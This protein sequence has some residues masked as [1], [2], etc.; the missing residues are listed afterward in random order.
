MRLSLSI[1]M[2]VLKAKAG[3]IL[4]TFK[5]YPRRDVLFFEDILAQYI[6]EC[7]KAGYG[8]E[9]FDIGKK[10]GASGIPFIPKSVLMLSPEYITNIVI[11][12]VWTNLGLLDDFNMVHSANVYTFSTRNEFITRIIGKNRFMCGLFA[13][14]AAGFHQRDA[15]CCKCTQTTGACSYIVTC[16]RK[17]FSLAAKD[18]EVYGRLNKLPQKDGF[19]LKKAL[20]G[21]SFQLEGNRMTFRGKTMLCVENTGFHLLGS[22]GILLDRLSDI[23]QSFFEKLVRKDATCN[24]RL[25]LLKT[26]LQSCGWGGVALMIEKGE[27]RFFI[28]HPPYGIQAEKDNWDFLA[29]FILGYLRTIDRKIALDRVALEGDTLVLSYFGLQNKKA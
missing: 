19:S 21:G 16:S 6:Q 18:F 23:T 7:E 2:D 26:I 28:E 17:P 11:K 10:W 9:I 12:N 5:I 15:Q 29:Y 25:V 1:Q 20:I 8:N 4:N 3:H 22:S 13:G 24:N 27:V 14:A